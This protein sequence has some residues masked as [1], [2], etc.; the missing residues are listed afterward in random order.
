MADEKKPKIDLK[1]RLGKKTVTTTGG[2][3]VPPPVGLPRPSGIP[4]PMFGQSAGPQ[5]P[6]IDASNP[7]SSIS[8]DQAPVRAEP[9][10]IK[11]EMSEEI[12]Q[13]QKKGRAKV[14]VL[15]LVTAAIGGLV[16]YTVGGGVERGKGATAALEGAE[17]LAKE[18]DESNIEIEKLADALKGAREKLSSGKYPAE[19]VA[20]LGGINVPFSGASLAGKGIGR[21]KP[22]IVTMLIS[23]SAGSEEANNQ[24][25]KIRSILTSAKPAIEDFLA[26]KEKPKIRWSVFMETGPH[27]PWVSMQPLP[28]P[29]DAKDFSEKKPDSKEKKEPYKWPETFEIKKG[30]QTFKLKRY[31]S[32]DPTRNR[33]NPDLMPVNPD[34][35]ALVCPTDVIIRLTR[36][37]S[38]LERVLRGDKTP[39]NERDGLVDT[40]RMLNE[41][42]KAIGGAG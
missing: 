8:A 4:A 17:A 9:A 29:F 33:E 14:V 40:G 39:G 36:E 6:K 35:Q 42:L 5:R 27:G 2:P 31:T 22:D 13:A 10:A 24:K 32:G 3:S 30:E 38:D 1:A 7:Y 19:E 28:A 26:Q 34:T 21:F 23:F 16:G 15:A 20:S 41:R 12:V 11:V 25:D 37:V 18:V